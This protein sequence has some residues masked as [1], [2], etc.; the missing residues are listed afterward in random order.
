MRIGQRLQQHA[1]DHAE[2]SAVGPDAQGQREDDHGG[3]A[4]RLGER[5]HG[6]L[7]VAGKVFEIIR[8]A[9]IA[10]FLLNLRHSAQTADGGEVRFSGRQAEAQIDFCFAVEMEAEFPVELTLQAAPPQQRA[11]TQTR[12]VP[13]AAN[14]HHVL[15]DHPD[16]QTDGVRKPLPLRQLFFELGAPGFCERVE[17]GFAAGVGSPPF[18]SQPA[19]AVPGGGAPDRAPPASPAGPLHWPAGCGARWPS[20]ASAPARAFGE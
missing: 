17:L 14:V 16:H 2:D 19:P 9:H 4:G 5:A 20:R 18:G 12:N 15:L 1:I 13:P 8:A 3:E 6:V 11:E 7:Q 10:A